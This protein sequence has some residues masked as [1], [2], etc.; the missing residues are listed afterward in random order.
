MAKLLTRQH[1]E[2][3]TEQNQPVNSPT[4]LPEVFST[5]P[6]ATGG[7]HETIESF[8]DVTTEHLQAHPEWWRVNRAGQKVIDWKKVPRGTVRKG[9]VFTDA[10]FAEL[11]RRRTDG[12]MK[13]VD[14][15]MEVLAGLQPRP[16][17]VRNTR[18]GEVSLRLASGSPTAGDRVAAAKL[19]SERGWGRP[20]ETIEI[21]QDVQIGTDGF[22]L[23][24]LS[25]DEVKAYLN[26]L[27]RARGALTAGTVVDAT[28]VTEV[29][30]ESK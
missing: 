2:Q 5:V 4:T 15:M 14:A 17:K 23:S 27:R 7:D 16:V 10:D 8:A 20:K 28:A 9:K 19:L 3:T 11:V 30:E 18:T 26:L 12:G 22:D 1:T 6:R 24:R 25:T 13:I 21:K 29:E